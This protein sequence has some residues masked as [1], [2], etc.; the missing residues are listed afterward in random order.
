MVALACQTGG[1]SGVKHQR[2]GPYSF[3]PFA[4]CSA[5]S[6]NNGFG[7][8]LV[9]FPCFEADLGFMDGLAQARHPGVAARRFRL[10]PISRG[11][12][13]GRPHTPCAELPHTECVFYLGS[14][15]SALLLNR[16]DK[17]S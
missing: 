14:G 11:L 7:A 4:E 9:N 8:F 13:E 3:F 17:S 1:L 12:Y 5:F 6:L 10:L 16:P 2:C 15:H